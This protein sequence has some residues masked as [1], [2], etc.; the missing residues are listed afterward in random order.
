MFKNHLRFFSLQSLIIIY[1]LSR[2][3]YLIINKKP[4]WRHVLRF[5]IFSHEPIKTV[6]AFESKDNNKKDIPS[7]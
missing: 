1:V 4:T 2:T 7:N 5:I 3:Y 6:E